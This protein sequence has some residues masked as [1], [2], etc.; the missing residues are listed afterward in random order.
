MD[1]PELFAVKTRIACLHLEVTAGRL[2]RRMAQVAEQGL[3][4]PRLRLGPA[5]CVEVCEYLIEHA[6]TLTRSLDMRLLIHSFHD[7]SS[8]K[9]QDAACHWKDL[10]AV[11]PAAPAPGLSATGVD[12][13]EPKGAETEGASDRGRDS[14]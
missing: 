14:G 2:R 6:A 5:A 4:A 1:V 9:K 11:T 10:V 7:R 13:L 3:R 8:G 12:R